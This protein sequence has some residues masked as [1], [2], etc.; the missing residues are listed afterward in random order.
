MSSL[1]KALPGWITLCRDHAKEILELEFIVDTFEGIWAPEEVYFP[2]MLALTGVLANGV[3]N[4]SLTFAKWPTGH[5]SNKAHP[6][7]YTFNRIDVENWQKGGHFFARKF[8]DEID[9]RLWTDIVQ[10]RTSCPNHK[11]PS[12]ENG[13]NHK[14]DTTRYDKKLKQSPENTSII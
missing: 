13:D 10:E 1:H 6:F 2:T 3:V 7:T 8:V 9:Y 12:L 14:S 11:R 4:S 5:K